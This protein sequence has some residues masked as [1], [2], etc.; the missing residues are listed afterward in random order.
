MSAGMGFGFCVNCI[1]RSVGICACGWVFLSVLPNIVFPYA[2]VI[3]GCVVRAACALQ[4]MCGR[5]SELANYVHTF[6]GTPSGFGRD[7]KKRNYN[8]GV[9][10]G[11]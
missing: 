11:I 4:S 3:E 7:L 8:Y 5:N 10:V 1:L 6:W 2:G 9:G